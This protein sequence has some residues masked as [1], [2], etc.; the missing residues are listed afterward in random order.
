MPKIRTV[1]PF[2][3]F[4]LA[5]LF[6]MSALWFQNQQLRELAKH[7]QPTFVDGGG[8]YYLPNAPFRTQLAP[9]KHNSQVLK[10]SGRVV[11]SDCM[12]PVPNA[13]VDV[14]QADENGKYVNEWYRGQIRSSEKGEYSFTTIIPKGYGEGTGYRPPHIHFK[15]FVDSKEIIT[16][17]MFFPDVTGHFEAAYIMKLTEKQENGQ[18]I[19]YGEHDIVLP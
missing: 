6:S 8:P 18:K 17:Q 4:L 13:I 1:L 3:F 11:K 16:S 19:M 15:I 5:L 12:T 2:A 10:V 9:E 7:C 14:W